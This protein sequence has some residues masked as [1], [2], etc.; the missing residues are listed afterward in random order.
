MYVDE[1]S[2]TPNSLHLKEIDAPDKEA[3]LYIKCR[4][5]EVHKVAIPKGGIAFQT[6]EGA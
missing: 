5:G 6:G 3:G 4:K 2:Y 1:A